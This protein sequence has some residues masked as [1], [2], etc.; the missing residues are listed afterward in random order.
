MPASTGSRLTPALTLA[1]EAICA[2]MIL[3]SASLGFPDSGAAM[4][5]VAKRLLKSSPRGRGARVPRAGK[6][7]KGIDAAEAADVV[8]IAGLFF[9]FAYLYARSM[10]NKYAAISMT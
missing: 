9:G 8:S 6:G 7:G 4:P 2:A 3:A 1:L 5:W 10:P